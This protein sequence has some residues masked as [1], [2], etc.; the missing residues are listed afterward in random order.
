[1]TEMEMNDHRMLGK[2]LELFHMEEDAPGMVYWHGQGWKIYRLLEDWIRGKMAD[3][4]YEEVRSPQLLPKSLWERS[5]HWE[6]F[7]QNMFAVPGKDGGR[8][9]ALKPMSCPCHIQI[10][11]ADLKSYRQLPV[12]YAEFG[13][14]H[15]DES[16]GSM[17]GLMRT[18]GFEQD[19]AHVL[20][21][22]EQVEAEVAR[23]VGLLKDSY[24]QLG[25]SNVRSALS[26]RPAA[27]AGSE[28]DW[29]LAEERLL[30]A[31]RSAGVEPEIQSGEGAFYGPKLEFA[32]QDRQGRHWQCGTIQLDMVLPG[33]LGA[34]FINEAGEH[35]VPVMLHHAVLGSMGRFIGM[36][37]EHHEGRLPF[38]LAPDQVAILPIGADQEPA[39]RAFAARLR[40]V[41]MRPRILLEESLQR[42]LVQAHELMIPVHAVIGRR[43]A[44]AGQ[45]M[46]QDGAGKCLHELEGAVATL[47]ARR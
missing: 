12:R 18:R 8:D 19:D 23:F 40:E 44:E 45:V 10:F 24:E 32:L 41:G 13:I 4:G 38:W 16:S 7:G 27:R 26:L 6:K 47:A 17:H 30:A 15:R 5:G 2:K 43:E 11:N 28:A 46:L 14:C 37:L 1:M 21:R 35:E 34:S 9:M 25:F 33:R 42:R 20:C 31:A 22:P 36:L 39:A 3:L 29:D